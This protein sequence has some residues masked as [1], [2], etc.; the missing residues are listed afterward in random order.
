MSQAGRLLIASLLAVFA[1]QLVSAAPNWVGNYPRCNR[2]GDLLKT[3]ALDIGVRVLTT[4]PL[5][6]E[7]FTSSLDFWSS[8][9]DLKWHLVESD[10]CAI[11]LV[12]GASE[13]FSNSL[14]TARSQ[15]PD[16]SNFAGWIAFNPAMRLTGAELFRISVH[17]VGHLLGLRH[18]SSA[19]SVMYFLDLD[20]PVL[21]NDQ[22]L[23]ELGS[24]HR[25]LAGPYTATD[26][27]PV[28]AQ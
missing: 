12:D 19:S 23:R 10:D 20:E 14:M 16:E 7:Q 5:L 6:A 22:D 28:T 26:R 13:L 27:N 15:L 2:S 24:K 3:G 8:I 9:L 4:N 11:E 18:N 1:C 17:E 25:L 21:L